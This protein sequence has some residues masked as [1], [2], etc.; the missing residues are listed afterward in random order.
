MT[1]A[2]K[3]LEKMRSQAKEGGGKGRIKKQH[4]KGKLTA[5]E[6]LE[7]LLDKLCIVITF[8]PASFSV[9]VLW[10]SLS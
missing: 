9:S 10:N 3:Q 6:R 4:E 7:L 1:T 5:R 2:I 8:A